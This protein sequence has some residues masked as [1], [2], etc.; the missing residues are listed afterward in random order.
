MFIDTKKFREYS[1]QKKQPKTQRSEKTK[2]HAFYTAEPLKYGKSN[3]SK[4]DNMEYAQMHHWPGGTCAI[5]GDSTI[6][7]IDE[8]QRSK[9]LDLVKACDFRARNNYR[10]TAPRS[11]TT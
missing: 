9:K 5:I 10:I 6:T 8:K 11:T 1:Q 4:R 3:Q 7:R 2:L